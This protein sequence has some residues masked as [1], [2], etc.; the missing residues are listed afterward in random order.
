MTKK[1]VRLAQEFEALVVENEEDLATLREWTEHM[2]PDEGM[3]TKL[4]D[5]GYA[6]LRARGSSN[7]ATIHP[8]DYEAEY[9]EVADPQEDLVDV[10]GFDP[11]SIIAEF[12]QKLN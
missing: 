12:D 5:E 8:V 10:L 6:F 2:R 11:A 7:V 3:L 9:E 1:I 4:V